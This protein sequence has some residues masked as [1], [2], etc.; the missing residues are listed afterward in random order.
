MTHPAAELGFSV[1]RAVVSPFEVSALS[2]AL[3]G[4]AGRSRAG[5]RH[6]MANAT[7]AAL[8]NDARLLTLAREEIGPTALPYRATLFDKSPTANWLVV[9]HQ[10][11]ALP[12]EARADVPGWG[13]WSTKVGVLYA[14]APA[15]ALEEVVALRVHL[16]DSDADNGP[17]RVLPGTHT[18][19]VLTDT[20]ILELARSVEPVECTVRAGGVV[21]MRPLLVHASSKSTSHAPRRVRH[22]EYAA[23]FV[24][25]AGLALAVA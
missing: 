4:I 2:R 18:R 11:T 9:W 20:A 10:D 24:L 1:R 7:V 16:D 12:I 21:L 14:H 5:A 6:L 23:S 8:A 3:H 15:Q 22:I 19:G 17:L 25:G 13:P